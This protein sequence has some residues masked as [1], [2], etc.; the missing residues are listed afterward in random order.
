MLNYKLDAMHH[1]AVGWPIHH[2]PVI[3]KQWE[4]F[5]VSKTQQIA[6]L[7]FTIALHSSF[8]N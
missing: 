3:A 1:F 7:F 5:I 6:C 4:W 2:Y 8:R